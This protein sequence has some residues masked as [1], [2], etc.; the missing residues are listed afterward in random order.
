VGRMEILTCYLLLEKLGLDN[1]IQAF[2]REKN[3]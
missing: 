1:G 2:E 3:I